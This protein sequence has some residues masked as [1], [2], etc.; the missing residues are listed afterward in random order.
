MFNI[1]AHAGDLHVWKRTIDGNIDYPVSINKNAY[2]EGSDAKPAGYTLGEV[3]TNGLIVSDTSNQGRAW[4]RCA[5]S[6]VVENDGTIDLNAFSTEVQAIVDG[7]TLSKVK[8]AVI[9]KFFYVHGIS[10]N[11]T[12]KTEFPLQTVYFVPSDATITVQSREVR[13]SKYQTVI[14]YPA[15][16]ANTTIEYVGQLGDKVGA[17]M[18]SYVGN[19]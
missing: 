9:G 12:A 1:L 6:L 17:E 5:D 3:K 16:P 2:Q 7:S 4:L 15:I 11:G 13:I 14:G 19:G 10:A 8:Q 18:G